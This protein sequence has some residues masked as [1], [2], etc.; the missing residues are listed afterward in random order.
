MVNAKARGT[1]K[2]RTRIEGGKAARSALTSL[3]TSCSAKGR[4]K[5]GGGGSR[6]FIMNPV[7]LLLLLFCSSSLCFP[8]FVSVFFLVDVF[9][10]YFFK[11]I[12]G[13]LFREESFFLSFPLN[14]RESLDS[15][16]F[17][18]GRDFVSLESFSVALSLSTFS[19]PI[20]EVSL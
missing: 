10:A 1:E 4:G 19:S 8:L 3:P 16:N 2:E 11:E 7:L 12:T 18:G 9:F 14:D 15:I 5:G 17:K 6:K 13:N 20:N